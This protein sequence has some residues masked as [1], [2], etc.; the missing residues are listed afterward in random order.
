M[1]VLELKNELKKYKSSDKDKIIIELYKR[2]PK[3]VKEDYNID[4]FIKNI[5]VK[6]ETKKEVRYINTLEKEINYFLQCAK[7]GLYASPNRIISKSERS[8]WRFKVKEFYKELNSISNNQEDIDKATDLLVSIFKILSYGSVNLTFSN[9]ETFRAVQI[10]Q[11]EFYDLIIKRKLKNNFS[12]SN[13]QY[14]IN[15]LYVDKD[16]YSLSEDMF[17][18]LIDNLKTVDMKEIALELLKEE[19]V[20]IQEEIKSLTKDRK[21][22]FDCVWNLNLFVITILK[23]YINLYEVESGIKYFQK[24]YNEKSLEIK[25]Y[26]LLEILDNN[27]LYKEWIEEYEEHLSKVNYRNSLKENYQRIK[28][29]MNNKK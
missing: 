25:E 5:D 24:Y 28:Q 16:P 14:V 20:K 10:P 18:T 19:V 21:S 6:K 17:D 3:R 4:E 29:K 1:K 9:W 2:I 7:M 12:K 23:I 15:L 13:L 22:T 27:Q 8:K 26:I 11:F